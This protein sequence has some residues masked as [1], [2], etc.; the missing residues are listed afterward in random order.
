[1]PRRTEALDASGCYE[2]TREVSRMK[3]KAC[4][5]FALLSVLA[6]ARVLADEA[7]DLDAGKILVTS[8][9]IP[10]SAEPEHV[11]RAVVEST[12]RSVWKV[13]SDCAHYKDHLPHIA[14]SAELSRAGNTVT[15][16]V[17]VALPFPA[18]N[19]TAVT[20][21]VH[22]ERSDGMKRSWKL[23]RGD[24]EFN[25]GSWTIESYRGGAA[26]LVTYRLHV[27]PKSFVPA[28]IR[29]A[30]QDKALPEMM[31]RV[32]AEAAKVSAPADPGR[33]K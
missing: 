24:Y 32:R 12:P 26:S 2:E 11:V 27:K 10:G 14:A 9:A 23:V 22:D 15:C 31:Q 6:T 21:A 25:D 3:L 16:Q 13:V 17:T 20:E 1:M 4:L 18:S 30:A 7:A 33:E 8:I 29:N 28:F 19:L 5:G